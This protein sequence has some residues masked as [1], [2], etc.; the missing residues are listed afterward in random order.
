MVGKLISRSVCVFI[1]LHER[2]IKSY[3]VR[4]Q[5]GLGCDLT[6]WNAIFVLWY[7]C[8]LEYSK[9]PSTVRW[10]PCVRRKRSNISLQ[11]FI[12]SARGE[13]LHACS[14]QVMKKFMACTIHR[15]Q[16]G[17][18]STSSIE[19]EYQN[20]FLFY[21]PSEGLH[22]ITN[23][24]RYINIC[25]DVTEMH[26]A[27]SYIWSF[28]WRWRICIIGLKINKGSNSSVCP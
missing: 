21:F 23:L 5:M 18:P 19:I 28:H 9:R 3:E 4:R 24:C 2:F 26:D 13:V 17:L 10:T 8:F 11:I 12:L 25:C 14:S 27:H 20:D 22:L 7:V 1:H 16:F 15:N 6:V